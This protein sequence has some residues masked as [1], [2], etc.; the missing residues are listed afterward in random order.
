MEATR[1]FWIDGTL[2]VGLV[3]LAALFSRPILLV[4][5]MTAGAWLLGHQYRFARIVVDSAERLEV[6]QSIA[7]GIVYTDDEVTVVLGA[8]LGRPA[9]ADVSIEAGLPVG[10]VVD[11]ATSVTVPAGQSSAATDL[12]VRWPIAGS[13]RF[14]PPIVMMNDG[15][16]RFVERFE[17]GP[18][19][20]L[21]VE[22]SVI[23]DVHVGKQSIEIEAYGRHAT[24]EQG[25]GFEPAELREYSST[26]PANRIDWKATARIGE[27][28]VREFEVETDR[29]LVV[30]MDGRASMGHG[31]PGKTK[32]DYARHVA[33]GFIDRVREAGDPIGCY[34]IGEDGMTDRLPPSTGPDHYVRVRNTIHDI[35][36]EARAGRRDASWT[37]AEPPQKAVR[38]DDGSAFATRLSPYFADSASYREESAQDPLYATVRTYLRRL[39]GPFWTVIFT[40]DTRRAEVR[41]T[42]GFARRTGS[43][44]L[45]FM[46]PTVLF[47]RDA[48]TDLDEAYAQYVDFDRFTRSLD[49]MER[50]SVYE[51]APRNRLR[52]VLSARSTTDSTIELETERSNS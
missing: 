12:S 38:L 42:V 49:R 40:D 1:R 32:L 11:G 48:E 18:T 43:R 25:G 31:P 36:P 37:F 39:E 50:V 3:A 7:E 28:H 9:P 33:L 41:R 2:V 29:R 51:I 35:D 47:D 46:T 6:T 15:R 27:P 10:A 45:V 52:T 26:D 21:D 34:T 13:F 23:Q 16:G 22:P 14:D 19:V 30:V 24:P 4:A 17:A 8:D 44:V 20:E 5:A